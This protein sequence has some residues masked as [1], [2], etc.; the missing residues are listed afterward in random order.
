MSLATIRRLGTA[1][2]GRMAV[3]RA[4]STR[5]SLGLRCGLGALPEPRR[6]RAPVA[7]HP[8]D[9]VGFEG[10][11]REL[12]HAGPEDSVELAR[13][14]RLCRAGVAGLYVA[15]DESGAPM[16]AQ[17]LVR[18]DAQ[19]PLHAVTGGLFPHLGP[20]EALLEGAY[21]FA[22]FRGLGAMAD[23]M[24]QLLAIA[25]AEGFGSAITYVAAA[26]VASL[27]GC[28]RVGFRLDH[29][30]LVRRRLGARRI[31]RVPPDTGARRRF[32]AAT[33]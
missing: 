15:A 2:L 3:R 19:E 27:K 22:A 13:R 31:D 1:E 5:P 23:G 16:Y 12:E 4:W 24:H 26:N 29:V 6:A 8:V 17:W 32:L 11:E 25:A 28:A 30:R 9:G 33:S 18:P 21:T 10:F 7:M 20:D 14:I